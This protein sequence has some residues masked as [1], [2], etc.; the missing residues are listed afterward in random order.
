MLIQGED[1]ILYYKEGDELIKASMTDI[2]KHYKE[3]Q[4]NLTWTLGMW[5]TDRK[6]LV[7]DPNEVMFKLEYTP[8]PENCRRI[9]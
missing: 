4:Y 2:Q 9:K 7:S 5:A 8:I 6:D 3:M 1:G